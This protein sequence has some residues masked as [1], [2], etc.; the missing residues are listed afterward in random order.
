MPQGLPI[1]CAGSVF[2]SWSLI[3]PGFVRCLNK[4]LKK[5]PS[6]N[7]LNL[8][9]ADSDSSIGAC[10]LASK[11]HDNKIV[12]IKNYKRKSIALDHFYIS[13]FQ[14]FHQ[15]GNELFSTDN[16]IPKEV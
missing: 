8:V 7:E 15:C 13:K 10:L 9:L 2:K 14:N 1:V 16:H 3:K 6:L 5:F 11:L 4:Q 12:L